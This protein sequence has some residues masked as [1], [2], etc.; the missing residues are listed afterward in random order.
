MASG[1]STYTEKLQLEFKNQMGSKK[2]INVP[3]Y[4]EEID[5]ED[6]IKTINEIIELELLLDP[7]AYDRHLTKFSA[8]RHIKISRNPVY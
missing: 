2:V 1:D 8:A 4:F 5:T 3:I 7:K 6:L